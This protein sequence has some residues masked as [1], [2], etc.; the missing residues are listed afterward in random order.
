MNSINLKTNAYHNIYASGNADLEVKLANVLR[1]LTKQGYTLLDNEHVS[2]QPVV[3][4]SV[5]GGHCE[6]YAILV[7]TA[8]ASVTNAR[9]LTLQPLGMTLDVVYPPVTLESI[10]N[11]KMHALHGGVLVYSSPN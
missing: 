6:R 4:V 8:V 11:P 3:V 2:D 9:C 7:N 5:R 10:V 1:E